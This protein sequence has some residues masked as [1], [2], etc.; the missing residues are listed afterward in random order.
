MNAQFYP[1]NPALTFVFQARSQRRIGKP[2]SSQV[3][4]PYNLCHLLLAS[5]VAIL[6][7]KAG[8]KCSFSVWYSA[9][10]RRK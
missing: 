3:D 8:G 4:S 1:G 6:S 7:A 10:P 9:M 2:T 5:S